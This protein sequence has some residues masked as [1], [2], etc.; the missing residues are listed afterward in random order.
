[1]FEWNRTISEHVSIT[2][3]DETWW[4]VPPSKLLSTVFE[5][6]VVTKSIDPPANIASE[7]D[8]MIF[9]KV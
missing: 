1:M 2:V 4:I 3:S 8:P 7:Y 6:K 5:V 9:K